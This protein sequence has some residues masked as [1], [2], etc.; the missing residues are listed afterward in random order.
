MKIVGRRLRG[1]WKIRNKH[2]ENRTGRHKIDPREKSGVECLSGLIKKLLNPFK[3]ISFYI[4]LRQLFVY[5]MMI[6]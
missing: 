2:D 6:F 5:K 1:R 3:F 4:T